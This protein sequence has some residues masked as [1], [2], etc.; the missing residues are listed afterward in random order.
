MDR[1]YPFYSPYQFTSNDPIFA[2][3]IDGLESDKILNKAES[4]LNTPYE[5]G[6]KNPAPELVGSLGN[7]DGKKFW[8]TY[9]RPALRMI[10]NYHPDHYKT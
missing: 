4:L 6:G 9:L 7:A 2:I 5:Y 8:L 3:D 10:S 1:E